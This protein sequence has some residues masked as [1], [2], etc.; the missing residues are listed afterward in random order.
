MKVNKFIAIFM[1]CFCVFEFVYYILET[2]G[3]FDFGGFAS[4]HSYISL[5][6]FFGIIAYS[7]YLLNIGKK[8]K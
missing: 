8:N 4:I 6:G 3:N 7:I 5:I 2:F 1:V